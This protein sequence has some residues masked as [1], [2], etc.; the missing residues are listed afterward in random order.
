MSPPIDRL[1]GAAVL[2]PASATC[3][4]QTYDSRTETYLMPGSPVSPTSAMQCDALQQEWSRLSQ[5][6]DK[7]HQDCLDAHQGEPADPRTSAS[8]AGPIC[9]HSACQS[10]HNA[11]TEVTQRGA[12][13]LQACRADVALY[14][15]NQQRKNA[16]LDAMWRQQQFQAQEAQDSAQRQAAQALQ[17]QQT[18]QSRLA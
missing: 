13:R 7:A 12:D 9:S 14:E 2:L 3:L 16:H 15:K 10:L 18:D 1:G 5:S 11:R 8:L 17:A 6:L 4:A